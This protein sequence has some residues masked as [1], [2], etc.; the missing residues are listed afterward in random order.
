MSQESESLTIHSLADNG[1]LYEEIELSMRIAMDDNV[2][3]A[4]QPGLHD[5]E[6]STS[7]M[8][9]TESSSL[10]TVDTKGSFHSHSVDR[11]N[12]I[13]YNE[14]NLDSDD[15]GMPF[16]EDSLFDPAAN[17]CRKNRTVEDVEES[18]VGPME[19]T[20]TS[21]GHHS[22]AVLDDIL[23]LYAKPDKGIHLRHDK[24]NDDIF[25]PKFL[26]NETE[27]PE[28]EVSP[29]AEQGAERNEMEATV[30][31]QLIVEDDEII[32]EEPETLLRASPYSWSDYPKDE[33]S[34][35]QIHR[36]KRSTPTDDEEVVDLSS[37]VKS[38]QIGEDDKEPSPNENSDGGMT[39]EELQNIGA[40][41]EFE[42]D[43]EQKVAELEEVDTDTPLLKF[44]PIEVQETAPSSPV[45]S[46]N[47]VNKDAMDATIERDKP[48]TA[49]KGNAV[50]IYEPNIPRSFGFPGLSGTNRRQMFKV[51][52]ISTTD[53]GGFDGFHSFSPRIL[54]SLEM[55][56]ES[57][58]TREPIGS[59]NRGR[60]DAKI[61]KW[62]AETNETDQKY[63]VGKDLS[64]TSPRNSSDYQTITFPDRNLS[65]KRIP[66]ISYRADSPE[67]K[68]HDDHDFVEIAS[69]EERSTRND[70]ANSDMFT[71]HKLR[72]IFEYEPPGTPRTEY[73]SEI[74]RKNNTEVRRRFKSSESLD[75]N[76]NEISMS[77]S[78]GMMRETTGER[79]EYNSV[80]GSST[81]GTKDNYSYSK[82]KRDDRHSVAESDLSSFEDF[83]FSSSISKRTVSAVAVI[84]P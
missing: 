63:I 16:V 1:N 29:S 71:F 82:V 49:D 12:R 74:I 61:R 75:E 56:R 32:A 37:F 39:L 43:D 77:S 65:N 46:N 67:K 5:R 15:A 69:Q 70:E 34:S 24:S 78:T 59:D 64:S 10:H 36:E 11:A 21:S 47:L 4:D 25:L 83:D 68:S 14:N 8:R 50:N 53:F 41:L 26:P 84:M 58:H 19:S 60:N 3:M 9:I 35:E 28:T 62:N 33:D 80:V 76:S 51:Q 22:D 44:A 42:F 13:P 40:D 23:A 30:A 2:Q 55:N 27:I 52:D 54:S 45:P 79:K 73:L 66:V 6:Y 20:Q 38:I 17:G 31:E 48:P 81:N 18:V 57:H 72:N 7:S